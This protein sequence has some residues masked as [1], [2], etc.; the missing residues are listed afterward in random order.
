[1]NDGFRDR[2]D[3]VPPRLDEKAFRRQNFAEWDRRWHRLS[4][5]ARYFV[6]HDLTRPVISPASGSASPILSIGTFPRDR[7]GTER[8]RFRGASARGRQRAS[9][10]HRRECRSA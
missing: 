2:Q 3:I 5:L 4:I 9:R 7:T 10:S 1:M 6:L 8:S